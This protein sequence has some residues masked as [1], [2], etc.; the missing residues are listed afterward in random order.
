M[1]DSIDGLQTNKDWHG[2]I[3]MSFCMA[4]T[5]ICYMLGNVYMLYGHMLIF[6]QNNIFRNIDHHSVKQ[7]GSRS[8]PVAQYY[9][10]RHFRDNFIFANSIK[11]HIFDVEKSRLGHDL[12]TSVTDRVISPF[13]E[14]L[15]SRSF[16]KINP[17]ENFR[18][19]SIH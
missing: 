17:R 18:I 13:H 9:K 5:L 1:S 11:R 6:L 15:F 16:A 10:F 2:T 14:G 3:G 4:C 8:G 19:Y 12:L 7:F